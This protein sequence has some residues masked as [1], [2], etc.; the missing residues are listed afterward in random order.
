MAKYLLRQKARELRGK[1]ISVKTIAEELG[2]SKGTVSLWVRDIILSIEQME[3]LKNSAL[4]GAELGRLKSALLQKNRRLK[5]IYDAKQLG[6][7]QLSKLTD[8]EFLIA[9]VAL[10]WGEGS[11]KSREFSFCN[12]D[13]EMVKFLI[14]WL[15]KCFNVRSEDIK[16]S[17]GINEIH[18]KR[19]EVVRK[20]WSEV[21]EIPLNQFTKTS[22]KKVANKKVYQNF[23]HHY[24]TIRIKIARSGALYY[25][26]LGLLEGLSVNM[27][28]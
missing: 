1:G 22:F 5:I 15:Q 26:V 6:V 7:Q 25:K 27:P 17:V 18:F 28:G 2:V 3:K 20:Y 23:D 10:Y 4:R 24:G 9:G 13:P 14:R 12:S 21:L 16:A 8:R 11:K 19:E